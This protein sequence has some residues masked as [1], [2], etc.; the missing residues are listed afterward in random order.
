[1]E[2]DEFLNAYGRV[3]MMFSLF[4]CYV[5][6]ILFCLQFVEEFFPLSPEGRGGLYNQQYN[7]QYI[8]EYN[9]QFKFSS[10]D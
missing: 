3:L 2:C 7:Q 6:V 8:Q 4:I 5:A 1:M 10:N 9:Q